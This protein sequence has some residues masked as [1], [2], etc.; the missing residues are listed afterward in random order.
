MSIHQINLFTDHAV[1]ACSITRCPVAYI[2]AGRLWHGG[3]VCNTLVACASWGGAYIGRINELP[4][5]S[6]ERHRPNSLLGDD[7]WILELDAAASSSTHPNIRI[8]G[9][10]KVGCDRFRDVT[11]GSD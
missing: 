9:F 1:L 7:R 6:P 8:N 4:E 2:Y 11:L 5:R 3:A 10:E